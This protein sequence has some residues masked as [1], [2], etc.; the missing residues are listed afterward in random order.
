MNFFRRYVAHNLHLKLL[1]LASA[2]M[3]WSAVSREPRAEVAHTV[4]VEFVNVPPGMAINSD[5]VPEVQIWLGGPV[6]MVRSVEARDLHPVIDLTH[7]QR[8]S[9]ERTYSLSASQIKAP[10][11]V[12]VLQVVP[13]EFHLSFDVLATRKVRVQPRVTGH[14]A[15]GFKIAEVSSDPDS[16][17]IRGP[18]SRVDAIT[19]AITDPVDASG[20]RTRQ[21]FTTAVYTNDPLVRILQPA[22]VHVTVIPAEEGTPAQ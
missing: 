16:V 6:R 17:S 9:A 1:A 11:G 2:T 18:R 8:V 13:S 10:Y 22:T 14:A 4:P 5:K 21:T 20:I 12:E 7:L 3:L 19:Q 15:A